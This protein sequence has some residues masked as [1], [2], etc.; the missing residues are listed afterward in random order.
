MNSSPKTVREQI[1]NQIRDELV[2]GNFAAGTML[3]ETELAKRLGVSRGP[4]R[5]AFLQLANEGFLLYQANRGVMVRHPPDS[6]DRKFLASLREQIE[7]YIVKKGLADVTDAGIQSVRQALDELR[8]ACDTK[9][10]SDIAQ[11]DIEFHKT[12]L[13]TCGGEDMIGTWRQLCAMMLF[14][15]SHLRD[16]E[17]AFQEHVAIFEAFRERNLDHLVNALSINIK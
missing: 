2:A 12:L 10:A 3:R 8:K 1:T 16:F 17:Q 9:V 6:D 11:R 4:V 5:D 13:T 15:Y 14:T 7:I